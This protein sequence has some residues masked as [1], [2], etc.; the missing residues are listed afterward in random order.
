[1]KIYIQPIVA[2]TFSYNNVKSLQGVLPICIT[3]DLKSTTW[4]CWTIKKTHGTQ[5]PFLQQSIEG[6]KL[7]IKHMKHQGYCYTNGII[8]SKYNFVI[9]YFYYNLKLLWNLWFFKS[10]LCKRVHCIRIIITVLTEMYFENT[11]F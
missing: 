5:M 6:S 1:M 10:Q 3:H 2:C 4:K 8:G 9:T 7:H 11:I